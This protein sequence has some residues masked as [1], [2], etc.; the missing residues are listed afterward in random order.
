MKLEHVGRCGFSI[1]AGSP[2]SG[3]H[4]V[5]RGTAAAAG[6]RLEQETGPHHL[7]WSNAQSSRR[8]SDRFPGSH[9]PARTPACLD[10]KGREG[11]FF[12]LPVKEKHWLQ[13]LVF[14]YLHIFFSFSII[15]HNIWKR[16]LSQ[17]KY[18]PFDI[19][20]II[21][22]ETG[23]S[24]PKEINMWCFSPSGGM[25]L[26]CTNHRPLRW[27]H[28]KDWCLLLFWPQVL[29]VARCSPNHSEPPGLFWNPWAWAGHTEVL[30]S[31][32]PRD[33]CRWQ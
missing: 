23:H 2:P 24:F 33:A 14:N 22:S 17:C 27:A 28:S 9:G 18:T 8:L 6:R 13:I 32:A 25:I 19:S 1:I 31:Q 7:C 26:M 12:I 20:H 11:F 10:L 30:Y 4:T 29:P 5:G 21:N 3:P 16:F 15:K